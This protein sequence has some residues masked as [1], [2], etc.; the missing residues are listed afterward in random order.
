MYIC[1]GSGL[2]FLVLGFINKGQNR[3]PLYVV[4]ESA[5]YFYMA[6]TFLHVIFFFPPELQ[7]KVICL[8]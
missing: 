8:G 3:E 1:N 5:V 4:Q 6:Y 7:I 2:F